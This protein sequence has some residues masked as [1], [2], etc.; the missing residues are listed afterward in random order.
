MVKYILQVFKFYLSNIFKYFI[1]Q[2]RILK[3]NWNKY[4]DNILV[5]YL[6][7][8]VEILM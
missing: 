7:I 6:S 5:I 8:Y 1:W 3:K 2:V 4:N